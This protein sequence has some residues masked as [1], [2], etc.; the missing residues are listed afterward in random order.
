MQDLF[1]QNTTQL[2]DER[3]IAVVPIWH[4][5]DEFRIWVCR[6]MNALSLQH[7][8]PL[9]GDYLFRIGGSP[10]FLVAVADGGCSSASIV[11]DGKKYSLSFEA[12]DPLA[13]DPEAVAV[14]LSGGARTVISTDESTL[15][16]LLFGKLK[17][18]SAF[19]AGKVQI[20]GDLP[21]FM[22]LVSLLKGRGIRP[23]SASFE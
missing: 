19:L 11:H 12:S 1:P 21:G 23:L 6:E 22:R 17:A 2:L 10:R 20:E 5:A 3:D 15:E 4:I 9:R 18:R 8:A 14:L 16:R 13:L 7:R